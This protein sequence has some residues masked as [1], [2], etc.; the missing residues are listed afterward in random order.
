MTSSFPKTVGISLLHSWCCRR[1]KKFQLYNLH[2]QFN[3]ISMSTFYSETSDSSI[4][5]VLKKHKL[6][7]ISPNKKVEKQIASFFDIPNH[8]CNHL[9]KSVKT[10]S[11]KSVENSN[12]C[13]PFNIS[14][15]KF[16]LSEE[17]KLPS[18]NFR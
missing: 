18:S 6:W 5:I 10:L 14:S 13:S 7:G 11:T 9:S 16:T 8:F 1:S 4:P 12:K 3:K 17:E 15:S 2:C